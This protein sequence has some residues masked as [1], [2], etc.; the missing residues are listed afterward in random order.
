LGNEKWRRRVI[1]LC[2]VLVIALWRVTGSY[3]VALAV[4]LAVAATGIIFALRRRGKT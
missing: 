1:G 2:I 4:A 3:P